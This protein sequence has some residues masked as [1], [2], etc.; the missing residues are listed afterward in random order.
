M[1]TFMGSNVHFLE[2]FIE[3][4]NGYLYTRVS[5]DSISQLFLLPYA[6]DHP[7]LF[8]RQWFRAA[9]LC[10]GQYCSS[11]EDFEEERLYLEL[12]FLVNGYSLDFIEY[13]LRQFFSRFN[14]KSNKS[15]NL[16]RFTYLSFRQEL[17]RYV[18]Q[19]KHNMEEE[20]ELHKH[21][22]VIHLY[23]L[24]DWGSRCQFNE[25]F[26]KFWSDILEQDPR[27][28]VY[29]LKIKLNTKHCFSSNTLLALPNTHI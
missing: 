3:N 4:K 26:H 2:A 13:H 25:K 29:G 1:V 7:R 24:F 17:F 18:D 8:H 9:L 20:Q 6:H 14:P 27:F 5:H 28:K 19:Q 23:Y 15:M 10:A 21:H 16:N 11:F 22:R 12:T